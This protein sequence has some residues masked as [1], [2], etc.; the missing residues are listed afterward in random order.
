MK[1][2]KHDIDESTQKLLDYI[3]MIPRILSGLDWGA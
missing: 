1:D 2:K 3:E